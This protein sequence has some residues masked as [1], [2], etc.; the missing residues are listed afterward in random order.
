MAAMGFLMV[1]ERCVEP[2]R[3]GSLPRARDGAARFGGGGAAEQK[4][5]K[6]R[7]MVPR[8]RA[9]ATRG[10]PK[11]TPSVNPGRGGELFAAGTPAHWFAVVAPGLQD[12]AQAE[13]ARLSGAAEVRAVAGGVEFVGDLGVG[14]AANHWLRVASRV[15]LRLGV[16][17]A[18]DFSK[19]RKLAAR[20]DWKS[21]VDPARPVRFEVTARSSRLYHTGAVAENLA[22]ALGDCLGQPV[23]VAA[24]QKE[25][26]E[27]EG[28]GRDAEEPQR[29]FARGERDAWTFSVDSS[30]ELL[31]RRGWRIEAGEAPLRETLAAGLLQLAQY[32]PA[33]P[34]VDLMCGSGTLVI[35]AAA[36]ALGLPPGRNRRF[37]FEHWPVF[38][39]TLW[40]RLQT[41]GGQVVE[42]GAGALLGFDADPGVLEIA[43]RN[44]ARAGVAAAV[45][46]AEAKVGAGVHADLALAA[47]PSLPPGPGL[48]I[49]NPPY[50][51]RLGQRGEAARLVRLLGREL[52]RRF[53]G[54]RAGVVLADP[55]WARSLGL[56]LIRTLA[57][58]NGG[59]RISYVI[60]E[61]P[62]PPR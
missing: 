52:R 45:A 60:A 59:L 46:F 39:P 15:L 34:F 33:R 13:V 7:P 41:G 14:M 58:H 12:V 55:A 10:L 53:S 62:G 21:V 6:A 9:P 3:R 36:L 18:R 27:G 43:R 35:E 5:Y 44:A 50:G 42:S 8:S 20:L 37:G 31:H 23:T 56:P 51:R 24:A 2:A 26:D 40:R 25:A 1:D 47:G 54:W 38:D 17:Q 28:A 48:V 49:V 30:G 4:G 61:V 11:P 19:L 22:L 16:V 32:D 29:I 57:L